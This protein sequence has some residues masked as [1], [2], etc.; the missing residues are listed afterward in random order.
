MFSV[1]LYILFDAVLHSPLDTLVFSVFFCKYV[2]CSVTCTVGHTGVFLVFFLYILFDVVYHG[3][4]DT[5][6]S[7][8]FLHTV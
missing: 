3:P 4:L 1:F 6:T 8:E 5:L 7:F 2:L